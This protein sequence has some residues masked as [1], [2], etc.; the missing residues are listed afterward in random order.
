[1]VHDPATVFH[2]GY[3]ID[4]SRKG[5]PLVDGSIPFSSTNTSPPLARKLLTLQRY[6]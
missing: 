2:S 6:W 3:E 4:W 5:R 1:M